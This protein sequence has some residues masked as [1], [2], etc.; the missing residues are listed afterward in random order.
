MFL[1]D[2]ENGEVTDSDHELLNAV[3]LAAGSLTAL[4]VTL[5]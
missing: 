2:A 3:S 1:L 5:M 4:A